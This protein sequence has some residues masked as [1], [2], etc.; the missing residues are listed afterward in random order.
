M[1]DTTE[2]TTLITGKRIFVHPSFVASSFGVTE[3]EAREALAAL[4]GTLTKVD[5]DGTI[6]YR[7]NPS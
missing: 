1:I 6:R 4:P 3:D 2:L 5:E 7:I